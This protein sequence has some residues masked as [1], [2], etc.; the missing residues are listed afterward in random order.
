MQITY[1]KVIQVLKNKGIKYSGTKDKIDLYAPAKEYKEGDKIVRIYVNAEHRK[2]GSVYTV[3][4][5]KPYDFM[6][7]PLAK[8]NPNHANDPCRIIPYEWFKPAKSY[9]PTW[10]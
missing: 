6:K 2:F 5:F 3:I 10:L 9:L 7:Y 1:E 4:G 8:E